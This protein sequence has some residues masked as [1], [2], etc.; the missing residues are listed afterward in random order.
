[1]ELLLVV[2]TEGGAPV[3]M[4]VEADP[5]APGAEIV[6]ALAR[7]VGAIEPITAWVS[8]T[9]APIALQAPLRDAQLC[10]GDQVHLAAPGRPS[11]DLAAG[12]PDQP[13]SYVLAVVG[14]PRAGQRFPLRAG[15]GYLLGR[16]DSADIN[17]G[18]PQA[19]RRHLHLGVGSKEVVASDAGSTNGTFLDGRR[20]TEPTTLRPGQVIE[21]GTTLLSVEAVARG[22]VVTAHLT[23]GDGREVYS[24]P[25]RVAVP[26]VPRHIRVP[27]PPMQPPRR[28]IP[29]SASIIPVI[30]GGLM[31][32][33]LGP[34]M[35]LFALMGPIV[36]GVSVWEDR[37][38]G[39]KEYA[40]ARA[41]YDSALV[42]LEADVHQ[43]YAA[44]LA[45]RRAAAPNMAE[46]A[47]WVRS[48]SPRLWERR[49]T[50]TDF[51]TVRVGTADLPSALVVEV[52]APPPEPGAYA[53]GSAGLTPTET[54]DQARARAL[55]Q[56]H[57]IDPSVPVDVGLPVTGVLGLAG[58]PAMRDGLARWLVVQAACLHSPRDLAIVGLLPT[59]EQAAAEWGW[60]R[61][62]PHTE[63]LLHGL[64]GGR[65]VA[66]DVDDVRALFGVV[67]DLIT[68]RRIQAERGVGAERPHPAVLVV[69]P[70]A[71]PI[72]HSSLSRLLAEGPQFAVTCIVAAPTPEQLPGEC[73]AVV[74]VG[75]HGNDGAVTVTGTGDTVSGIVVD[76][77]A[78]ALA[79]EL[80]RRL[81]PLQDATASSTSG[82]VPRQVLLLDLL[83]LPDPDAAAVRARWA[84]YAGTGDLGAPIGE[85]AAGP[86]TVDLRR[87]G[88][89]GLTAGTTGAGKSELLQ[90]FIGSLAATYPA[91]TLTFVLVD[92]KGGAAF[93][94]CVALPHTVGFFTDLDAHL[95]GRA[96]VSLNA[97]LRRR[98][99]IL[100]E[101]GCKD[102]PELE[103]RY[104]AESPA[105]LFI[106]FDE[107]AFLKKE[108]PEFVAGVIDIAQRGRSLGV[109][110]MLATQRP[111]GVVDDNIRANTNLRIILRVAD[112]QD[113]ND[114]LDRPDA[115]RIPK[116]L[117][118]RGYLRRGHSDIA[119]V[120]SAYANARSQQGGSTRQPTTVTPFEV[121]S[122]LREAAGPRGPRDVADERP[123]DLQRLVAAIRQAHVLA[124]IPDQPKPW[125]DPLPTHVDLLSLDT[126]APPAGSSEIA[127]PL[128]MVDLPD[129]QTQRLAWYDPATQGHL[130]AYGTS[131]TGKSQLLRC[132]AAALAVRA[133][134]D[135]VHVYALDFAGRGL[136]QLARLP[137]VGGVI[138]ADDPERVDRLVAMLE[139][140]VA[141]RTE[142]LGRANAASLAEYRSGGGTLPYLVVL[143]DGYGAFRQTYLNVDRGE[144]LE[145]VDRLVAQGR[146][147]G[148]TFVLT[149]D[150][151]NAVPTTLSSAI[152]ERLVLRMAEGDEYASLGLPTALAEV[153][154]APGRGFLK[155]T[156]VQIGVL[157]ADATGPGQAQAIEGL[158]AAV[159][160]RLAART[161]PAARLRPPPVEPLPDRI[162]LRTVTI[163]PPTLAAVPFGVSGDSYRPMS[164]DLVDNPV[165]VALGPARSGRTT[166]LHT[167]TAGLVAA[168]PGVEAYLLAP[169]RTAL[170]DAPWWRE[171]GRGVDG[172]DT[173]ARKLEDVLRE[174]QASGAGPDSA[175]PDGAGAGSAGGIPPW[176]VVV[177]DGDELVDT[178]GANSL[179]TLVRRGR[180]LGLVLVVALQTH[181]AHRAFGGW[182]TEI[183]KAKHA[184][185]LDP[186]VDIDGD[187]FGVR[188]PRKASRR[189][190]AGRG[191]LVTRG[192]VDYVQVACPD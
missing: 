53:G 68:M 16:D 82:E 103:A 52:A 70:G 134:P 22:P 180:D 144:L 57:A 12:S 74:R 130:L 136:A 29:L 97:E 3:E 26:L 112:E 42:D 128:G 139:T 110:L 120:Q 164:I 143:L 83:E 48:R 114:V 28:K 105:N 51:L 137:Q 47:D 10:H 171:V 25:P 72:P 61:W 127:I 30:M 41:A 170:L 152:T 95:A 179:V 19:S 40:A 43:T 27:A 157:G 33:F 153:T 163:G 62:L 79:T 174:R 138:S 50:D 145:R 122:G 188:F 119:L 169:R 168:Q 192:P 86:V 189:F 191:Y 165:F 147:V 66:S 175:G 121:R 14:G 146:A 190:P 44:L 131:G 181:T 140:A 109:H 23:R 108:V 45:A 80:A 60:L 58:N 94:D 31:A 98:E 13:A 76:G 151:R 183:R 124:G 116:G 75:E 4:R 129:Q 21:V 160:D 84:R 71:V 81:A 133:D 158:A 69:I 67:D 132:V 126:S 148:L 113:S 155:G 149:A 5:A 125:L 65:S 37:K 101:H 32:Y 150:R 88:P 56:A 93:K 167:V 49:A 85:G 24:R 1:M 73:R 184:I 54:T 182:V 156:E 15:S 36:L 187:L 89:H 8:R 172:C 46:L 107:F 161:G 173:L 123:T 91:S 17:L 39:R 159:Q 20:L 106:V 18:D 162:S 99:E 38:S 176:L 186:A 11:D 77:L 78:T 55:A 111:S 92:Y 6:A 64:P 35:L 63:T 118:G 166:A 104:P 177:D 142:L 9:A 154:L 102:L 34:I 90:A 7:A 96:L 59:T 135:L 117:P 178:L 2:T 185:V 100:R 115:A 87:D 141:E